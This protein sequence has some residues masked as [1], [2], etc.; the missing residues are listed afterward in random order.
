ME[1][2]ALTLFKRVGYKDMFNYLYTHHYKDTLPYED[3]VNLDSQQRRFYEEIILSQTEEILQLH[4]VDEEKDLVVVAS[5]IFKS[6]YSKRHPS[7]S[8][9]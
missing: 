1:Y 9:K 4:H 8:L 5:A 7:T 2:S 3:I 6:L